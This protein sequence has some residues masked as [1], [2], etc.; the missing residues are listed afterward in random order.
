MTSQDKFTT[1]QEFET[2]LQEFEP[3][4][5]QLDRAAELRRF[6]LLYIYLP[7]AA[8]SAII[9]IA[10]V[11][12]LYLTLASPSLETRSTI[13]AVAD[14]FLTLVTIPAMVLCAI[15][16]TLWLVAAIQLRQ[17][18]ASPVRGTQVLFWRVSQTIVL[19]SDD[20]SRIAMRIARP[21]IQVIALAAYLNTLKRKLF[22][23]FKRR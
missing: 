16:P 3:T 12:L 17:R 15:V 9:V 8:G 18:D 20:I 2:T 23:L 11:G 21:F 1:L 6:N 10:I 14:A 7:I 13:S 4:A 5:S 19:I 22:G